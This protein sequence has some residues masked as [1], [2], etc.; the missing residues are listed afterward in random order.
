VSRPRLLLVPFVTA[1]EWEKILPTLG[2]WADVATFDPPGVGEEPVPAGLEPDATPDE[3][4]LAIW[5]EATAERGLQEVESRGWDRYFIAADSYGARPAVLLACRDRERVGGLALGHAMLAHDRGGPRPSVNPEIWEAMS[6]LM[7]TD[8]SGFIAY[9]IAQLTQGAV[10]DEQAARWMTRFPNRGLVTR[11]W[12]L[13]GEQ[14]EPVGD[15]LRELGLP[16]LLAQHVGCLSATQ[17]GF[18]DIVAAFPDA[19]TA[20]CPEACAASPAFAAALRDF[21]ATTAAA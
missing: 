3:E 4:T 10:S 5:R 14:S 12:T 19:A 9:G 21:C 13:L 15:E 17:E 7:R 2:E 11:L 20:A 18:E 1:L 6:N 16:L 8:A